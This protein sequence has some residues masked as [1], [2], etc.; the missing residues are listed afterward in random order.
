MR[1]LGIAS[2]RTQLKKHDSV[3]RACTEDCNDF[4]VQRLFSVVFV[5]CARQLVATLWECICLSVMISVKPCFEE[6]D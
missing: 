4:L 2:H 5:E 1:Q 6:H 3:V